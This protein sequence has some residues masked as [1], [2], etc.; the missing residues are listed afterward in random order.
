MSVKIV[1]PNVI[2]Q[3]LNWM[4]APM[5]IHIEQYSKPLVSPQETS[6]QQVWLKFNTCELLHWLTNGYDW[7][8]EP[9]NNTIGAALQECFCGDIQVMTV[10]FSP[11]AQHVSVSLLLVVSNDQMQ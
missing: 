8:F 5:P 4:G 9:Q 2:R 10:K 6:L 11:T 3:A 7:E 1:T